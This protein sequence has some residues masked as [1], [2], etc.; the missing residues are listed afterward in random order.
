[1][2]V[3]DKPQLWFDESLPALTFV[4]TFMSFLLLPRVWGP[5]RS[6]ATGVNERSCL[7]LLESFPALTLVLSF[8]GCLLSQSY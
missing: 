4:F 6:R 1:M 8:I 2:N 3:K 5:N 7:W